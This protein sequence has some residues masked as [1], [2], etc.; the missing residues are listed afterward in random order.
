MSQPITPNP[1]YRRN[2]PA[3][4]NQ[5]V[6]NRKV[7]AII[8]LKDQLVEVAIETHRALAQ[9]GYISAFTVHGTGAIPAA[10]DMR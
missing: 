1:Q 9:R 6:R 5:F 3:L 4:V 8:K 7:M 10:K 2:A